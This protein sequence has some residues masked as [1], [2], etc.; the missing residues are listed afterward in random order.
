MFAPPE[1]LLTGHSFLASIRAALAI[2]DA[3]IDSAPSSPVHSRPTTPPLS[4]LTPIDSDGSTHSVDVSRWP[5][6]PQIS[7]LDDPVPLPEIPSESDWSDASSNFCT[8]SVSESDYGDPTTDAESTSLP[9]TANKKKRKRNP[10]TG[11]R[12]KAAR[13]ARRKANHQQEAELQGP[14]S[15]RQPN[16]R[17]VPSPITTDLSS[18]SAPVQSTGFAGQHLDSLKEKHI[19]RLSELDALGAEVIPWDGWCV[20]AP[21]VYVIPH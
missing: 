6:I 10:N 19:W 4:P 14:T 8:D 17:V 9:A 11:A 15:L 18:T 12:D 21:L 5:S 16:F 7:P 3:G 20:S 2:D 1:S 13:K